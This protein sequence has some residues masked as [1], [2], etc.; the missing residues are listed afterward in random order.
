MTGMRT[1]L[2]QGFPLW[3]MRIFYLANAKILSVTKDRTR[4]FRKLDTLS[5]TGKARLLAIA[6]G[7]IALI[8]VVDRAIG[9]R[10][11]LGL[12]Y[13]VPMIVA[14]NVLPLVHILTMAVVCSSLRAWF[15]LPAPAVEVFFRFVFAL[16]TYAG[17]GL[18]AVAFRN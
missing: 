3:E 15:D 9:N 10:A 18:A 5:A 2:R 17:S 1:I 16:M 13:I 14:G 6:C 12:L 8:A 11:S 4:V 7:M